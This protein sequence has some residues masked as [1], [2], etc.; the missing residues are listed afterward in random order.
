MSEKSGGAKL[1]N[2]DG[3]LSVS[4]E[5]FTNSDTSVV[6]SEN[7]KVLSGDESNPSTTTKTDEQNETSNS[8][9]KTLKKPDKILPCPR[10]N[11]MDTKFCYYN[12]YNVN[13]PRHFC[14]NCQRY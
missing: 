8:Q 2:G 11:S 9:E 5:E 13:Q 4:T 3:G 1:E 12:N 14:K 10:C 7:S 6:R